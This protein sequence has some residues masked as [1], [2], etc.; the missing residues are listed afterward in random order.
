M[1]M[2]KADLGRLPAM[3]Y[4][5]EDRKRWLGMPLT[6]TKYSLSEDRIF[7]ERGLLNTKSDEILLYRVRDLSVRISLGQRILG[8]GTIS[9]LSSDQSMPRLEIQNVK[10]PR[11][12]KELLHQKVEQAKA[13]RRL[14]AMELMDGGGHEYEDGEE[15][16]FEDWTD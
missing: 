13:A 15:Q 16:D 5:W 1:K 3:E 7:L 6:F 10:H 4:L 8:V 2:A 11:E 14:R 12:V 9:V